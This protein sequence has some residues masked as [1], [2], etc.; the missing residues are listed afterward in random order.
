[1]AEHD[2]DR[3]L[4]WL[5]QACRA[6]RERA[7]RK[8]VQ[9]AA[10]AGANQNTISRFERGEVWPRDLG[11]IVDAYVDDVEV[12]PLELWSEALRLWRHERQAR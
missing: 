10:S 4:Y 6:A 5:A 3:M 2:A 9:V 7:G 8:Q 1:M 12:D 11:R